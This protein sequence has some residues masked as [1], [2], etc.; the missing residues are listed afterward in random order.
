MTISEAVRNGVAAWAIDEE[1]LGRMRSKGIK[2]VA[3]Q[4]KEFGDV[5][6]TKLENFYNRSLSKFLDFSKRGGTQQRY[7]PLQYFHHIPNT[8]KIR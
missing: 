2:Y 3:V 4:V 5:Y 1:T 6:V 8:A 7:L